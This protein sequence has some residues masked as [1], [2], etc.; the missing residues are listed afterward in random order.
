MTW[1][2]VHGRLAQGAWPVWQ[3]TFLPYGQEW[4]P[5]LTTNHYNFIGRVA[6]PVS[7]QFQVAVG[8]IICLRCYPNSYSTVRNQIP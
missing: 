1:R 5:Q 6:H 4:N 3:A 2:V 8:T 7:G